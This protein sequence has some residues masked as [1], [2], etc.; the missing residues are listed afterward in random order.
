MYIFTLGTEKYAVR[1]QLSCTLPFLTKGGDIG[2][3]NPVLFISGL[4]CPRS[5]LDIINSKFY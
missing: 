3:I 5:F 2:Q 1:E 4:S